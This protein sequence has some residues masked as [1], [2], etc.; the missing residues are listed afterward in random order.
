MIPESSIP[1]LTVERQL[2]TDTGSSTT[3]YF[4]DGQPIPQ[5]TLTGAVAEQI[6]G[7]ALIQK[8]L[9]NALRWVK[10][11]TTLTESLNSTG[12]TKY[13]QITDRE[14]GDEIKCLFVASLIF[15][16]KAFTEAAGRHAQM[17]RDWLDSEYRDTHDYF[18]TFRHN[19]AAHS[20]DEKLEI[21]QSYILLIPSRTGFDIRLG[22]S[23][24]QPDFAIGEGDNERFCGLIAHAIEKVS[25]KYNKAGRKTIELA[26]QKGAE[27]WENA[28][29]KGGSVDATQLHKDSE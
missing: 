8:D 2:D 1:R 9:S 4:W 20:G 3:K 18:M 22:T 27:F 6:S 10:K 14:L 15:Y 24:S 17:S 12:D 13:L 25:V 11:A 21:G 29:K 23:R 28:A 16:A 19:M 26:A 7:L 5:V